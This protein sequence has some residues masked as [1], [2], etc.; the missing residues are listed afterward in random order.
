M[1]FPH[2]KSM[3]SEKAVLTIR[4]ALS[5]AG[6]CLQSAKIPDPRLSAEL[7]LGSVLGLD[8][9]KIV[10]SLDEI[11]KE[12]PWRFF[13]EKVLRRAQHEPIAYL[14]G[15]KE[16]WSLDFTVSPAVL[17]PRPETEILVEE[18]LK[19]LAHRSGGKT[20]VELGTGSG[21]VSIALAK[22]M[23]RS[24]IIRFLATDLSW[25][26]LQIARKNAFRHGVEDAITFVQGNWLQPF[27]SQ[28]RWID[29]LVSNPPYISERDLFHLPVTVRGYE[30]IK[31]LSG[32]RDGLTAL[33][34]ILQQAGPQL[35]IGGCLI[36]EIGETQGDQVLELAAEHQYFKTVLRRDYSGKERILTACYHG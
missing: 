28:R 4:Q 3:K 22:S 1:A 21:A 34:E 8:R 14:I 30:P 19:D 17:I 6:S 10:T 11:L 9:A 20:L 36:L 23:V 15:Q 18:A 26:A 35:K 5:W 16:F 29:L 33:R 13:K 32:G 12:P 27:S 24:K 2:P 25:P 7:L 31:A